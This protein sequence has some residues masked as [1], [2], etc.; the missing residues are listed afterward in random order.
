MS[1]PVPPSMASSRAAGADRG[2][3][4]DVVARQALNADGV[5]RR[6]EPAHEDA[7]RQAGDQKVAAR[8]RRRDDVVGG[9]PVDDDGVRL[10][11][12]SAAADRAGEVGVDAGQVG[13]GQVVDGEECRL[14]PGR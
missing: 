2:G 5:E 6:L 4:D 7:G 9:S 14:R 13:A 11:I 1:L 12:A 3:V 8:K 10:R